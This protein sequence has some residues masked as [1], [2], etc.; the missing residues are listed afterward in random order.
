[1]K[2]EHRHELKTNELAE[3]LGNLPKW[4]QEN[5]RMIIYFTVVIIAVV[6]AWIWK[7][8][9]K[10]VV[11]V[12]QR[13]QLSGLFGELAQNR[14]SIIQQQA[15]GLDMSYTLLQTVNKL[16]NF[17]TKS[18]DADM[19]ALALIKSADAL[20]SELHYRM[21]QIDNHAFSEQIDKARSAYEQAIE[22][23]QNNPSLRG[24][25]TMGLGLCEEDIRNFTKA[26][27]IYR[28]ILQDPNFAPT[29]AAASANYRLEVMGEYKQMALFTA[30]QIAPQSP[31]QFESVE[32]DMGLESFRPLDSLVNVPA[33]E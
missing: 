23:T 11:S 30:P 6:A 28:R 20:R 31:L 10:N 26:E 12:N 17:A 29:T 32:P 16:R 18:R 14:Y 3:W 1:M 8:Y 25:A 9:Q 27:G 33:E 4:A 2:S 15:Q 22:K 5:L 19:S 21:G 13:L 24:I 7:D